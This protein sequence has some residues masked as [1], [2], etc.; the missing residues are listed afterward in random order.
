MTT[1]LPS[2][3]VHLELHTGD[4]RSASAFYSQ[5]LDWRGEQI[6]TDA[7]SYHALRLGDDL[8]GGI[9]ECSAGRAMCSNA[10]GGLTT[11]AR[12]YQRPA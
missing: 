5:L 1:S 4:S 2:R 6:N 9:V 7:G 12:T 8:G 10:L 11:T 3:I